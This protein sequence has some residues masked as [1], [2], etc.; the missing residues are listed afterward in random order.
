MNRSG[1]EDR[2][3]V[4]RSVAKTRREKNGENQMGLHASSFQRAAQVLR[5]RRRIFF[6]FSL[7]FFYVSSF[8]PLFLVARVLA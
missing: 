4:T 7:F 6:L 1:G 3:S 5:F 8:F 2:E